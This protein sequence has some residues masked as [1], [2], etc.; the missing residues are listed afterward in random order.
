[1]DED[2][3]PARLN[4]QSCEPVPSKLTYNG[5]PVLEDAFTP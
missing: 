4:E 3:T 5:R 1:M 2:K